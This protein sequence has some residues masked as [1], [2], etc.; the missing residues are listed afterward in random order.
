[1][2]ALS[3]ASFLL[4]RAGQARAVC[5]RRGGVERPLR[6]VY[7][8][9]R[10]Q[11]AR[12][13]EL[14]PGGGAGHSLANGV[15]GRGERQPAAALVGHG[16]TGP[17]AFTL[18]LEQSEQPEPASALA[19]VAVGECAKA[20]GVATL[21]DRG[22]ARSQCTRS[23]EGDSFHGYRMLSTTFLRDSSCFASRL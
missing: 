19:E 14:E 9:E 4:D 23:T 16:E 8:P 21:C 13:P 5:Q 18:W 3:W 10:P 22:A 15:E 7:A 12:A 2:S 6:L 20:G 11:R 17:A 1:M